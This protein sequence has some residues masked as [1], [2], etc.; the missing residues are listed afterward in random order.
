MLEGD[1]IGRR[2]TEGP[3]AQSFAY[4]FRYDGQEHVVV[5]VRKQPAPAA[6]LTR[7]ELAVARELVRGLSNRE[8][9]ALRGTSVCTV[10]NQVAALMRRLG[11]RSRAEVAMRLATVDLADHE[12][13]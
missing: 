4:R 3:Q 13:A 7:A 10:A 9:A 8:I 2:L 11:L 12:N 1:D 6:P 5:G